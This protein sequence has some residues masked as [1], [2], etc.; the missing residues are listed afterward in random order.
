MPKTRS[1]YPGS[2]G[3]V[4]MVNKNS[5]GNGNGKWQGLPPTVGHAENAR[6]INIQAGST[7]ASRRQVFCFNALGGVGKI[8]TMFATTADGVKDCKS[9]QI[10]SKMGATNKCPPGQHY[11]STTNS[12]MPGESH[13]A[14]LAQQKAARGSGSGSGSKMTME[15]H[16][17]SS[18]Y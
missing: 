8:S 6:Y 9:S 5:P 10:I 11:M 16:S 13:A 3:S 15:S 4:Y 14:Y 18:G 12:C 1:M 7:E 2:S 17:H